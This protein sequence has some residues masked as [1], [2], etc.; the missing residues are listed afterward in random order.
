MPVL[1]GY[2]I[3][4]EFQGAIGAFSRISGIR[5]ETT[6]IDS[7]TSTGK[8]P[9][10]Q[11][12]PGK[13]NCTAVTF[14]AGYML[15]LQA[16]GGWWTNVEHIQTGDVNDVRGPCVITFLDTNKAP[17][18]NVVL[19]DAWPSKWSA[20]D[21]SIQR[22]VLWMETIVFQCESVKFEWV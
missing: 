18:L 1:G 19:Q 21:M 3:T 16:G 2:Q 13:Y 7:N 12:V 10:I 11:K 15:P 22:N 5:G 9:F 20:S 8:M 4:V 17:V 6:P 14:Q